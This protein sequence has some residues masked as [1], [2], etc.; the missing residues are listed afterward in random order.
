MPR[1][2]SAEQGRGSLQREAEQDGCGQAPAS[3][4]AFSR[5]SASTLPV[6]ARLAK[7][8]AFRRGGN[9]AAVHR[10]HLAGVFR[11]LCRSESGTQLRQL[12][13]RY[14][15]IGKAEVPASFEARRIKDRIANIGRGEN[16]K[17]FVLLEDPLDQFN[18]A[19][20]RMENGNQFG[21]IVFY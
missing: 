18:D 1:V 14:R 16:L 3:A 8:Q 19:L 10:H 20:E 12:G 13:L 6:S 2:V 5:A 9:A 17:V 15:A 4:S 7:A 11:R 21:K